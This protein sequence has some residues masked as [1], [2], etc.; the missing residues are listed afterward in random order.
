MNHSSERKEK[1]WSGHAPTPTP[2][3]HRRPP[4]PRLHPGGRPRP[5][6]RASSPP[7]GVEGTVR[8]R[9]RT[10]TVREK[11]K[12][13]EHWP[14]TRGAG[15]E[16]KNSQPHNTPTPV[17]VWLR[18]TGDAPILKQQRVRVAR[19]DPFARVVAALRSK[20]RAGAVLA[21]VR[22]AFVPPLDATVG[23]LAAAY[24]TH[25]GARLT[26]NYALAPAWG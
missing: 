1:Q 16:K 23:D 20:T 17:I 7:A 8:R 12:R 11:E 22:E 24:G 25:G 15:W 6:R 4:P 3:P 18:P 19:S 2:G 5:P 9:R 26:V 13:E 14:K 10:S 21:Y